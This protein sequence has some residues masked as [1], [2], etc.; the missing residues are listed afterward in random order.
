M[1]ITNL[2]V[3]VVFV[4]KQKEESKYMTTTTTVLKIDQGAIRL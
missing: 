2:F 3:S 4:S 1:F